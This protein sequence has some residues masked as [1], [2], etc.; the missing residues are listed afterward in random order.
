MFYIP[1]FFTLKPTLSLKPC[2]G[3]NILKSFI[4]ILTKLCRMEDKCFQFDCTIKSLFCKQTQSQK[5]FHYDDLQD[6]FFPYEIMLLI[7]CIYLRMEHGRTLVLCVLNVHQTL[8]YYYIHI[9]L[10]MS[11]H[12]W[13]Y[14]P[15]VL[16]KWEKNASMPCF[17]L[18][19]LVSTCSRVL[20]Y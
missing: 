13:S 1:Y 8:S 18:N 16:W 3:I 6:L 14:G 17:I 15:L 20:R 2:L 12:T 11:Y 9:Q 4:P 7:I 10:P 5:V 19:V